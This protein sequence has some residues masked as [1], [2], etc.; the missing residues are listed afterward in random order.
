M[1]E[2]QKVTLG[3]IQKSRAGDPYYKNSFF[4]DMNIVVGQDS[5][6]LEKN[7][8]LFIN[9]E[10]VVLS[11]KTLGVELKS[12]ERTLTILN[13]VERKEG[14]GKYLKVCADRLEVLNDGKKIVFEKGDIL[15]L[16]SKEKRLEDLA[17]YL[18]NGY[19]TEDVYEERVAKV[20]KTPDFVLAN[21][22]G[23]GKVL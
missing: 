21:V 1:S 9:E 4:N 15:N 22:V 3:A 18:E 16:E 8:A 10:D 20:E 19:I 23:K 11:A 2:T 6:T 7:G 17:Y 14:G 13:L 12:K 5:I